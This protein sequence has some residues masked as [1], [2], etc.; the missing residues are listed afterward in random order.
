MRVDLIQKVFALEVY[1]CGHKLSLTALVINSVLP[2]LAPA[3]SPVPEEDEGIEEDPNPLLMQPPLLDATSLASYHTAT[4]QAKETPTKVSRSRRGG[5]C[6]KQWV[7]L[8]S[9]PRNR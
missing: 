7:W 3:V 6:G 4:S 1:K 9:S 2:W 8:H 5:R